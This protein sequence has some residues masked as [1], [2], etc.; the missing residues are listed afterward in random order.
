MH[1]ALLIY[2]IACALQGAVILA[3]WLLL[4]SRLIA[5]ASRLTA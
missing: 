5:F 1:R 4:H 3:L 2:V